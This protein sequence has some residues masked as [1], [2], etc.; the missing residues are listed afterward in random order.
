MNRF[1]VED[2]VAARLTL[3]ARS[4]GGKGGEL[5]CHCPFCDGKRKFYVNAET[6]RW[7]CY[8][9]EE[10]GRLNALI[11]KV[12]GLSK[13]EAAR[14]VFAEI[15]RQ[16]ARTISQL[17]YRPAPPDEHPVEWPSEFVP[18]Y[19]EGEWS[20]PLYLE[21]RRVSRGLAREYGLGFCESGRYDGR[22]ILPCHV[23]G[24]LTFFQGRA[25][26]DREPKY[27]SPVHGKGVSLYG[28]DEAVS[29]GLQTV[30]LVEGPFDVLGCARAGI[31][32]VGLMGKSVSAEQIS[33]LG[34]CWSSVVLLLDPGAEDSVKR[35]SRALADTLPVKIGKLV[36]ADPGKALITDLR[37][38]FATAEPF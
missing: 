14:F 2:Y 36:G 33:L 1:P 5:I 7:I 16:P 25:I 34:D 19:S 13:A 26:D 20:F 31:P 18:V 28:F 4:E 6:G 38:A 15:A 27:L 11:E 10:R 21:E 17:L 35:V 30:A 12:D 29:F 24:E 23:N 32:A 9:C 8:K 22:V 3:K 37:K